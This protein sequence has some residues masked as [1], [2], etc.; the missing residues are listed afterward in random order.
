VCVKP[1]RDQ[2]ATGDEDALPVDNG[3][4]EPCRE[5]DDQIAMNQRRPIRG[6]NQANIRIGGQG[7][8]AALNLTGLACVDRACFHLE[9]RSYRLDGTELTAS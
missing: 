2:A 4:F 5:P 7:H 1:V 6:H 9:K 8:D 3:Q